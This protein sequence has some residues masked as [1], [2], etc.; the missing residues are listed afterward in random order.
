MACSRLYHTSITALNIW[1]A[2]GVTFLGL[3][4]IATGVAFVIS[5]FQKNDAQYRIWVIITTV[6]WCL[7]DVLSGSYSVLLTH[8]PLLGVAVVSAWIHDRP[9]K[10]KND[11]VSAT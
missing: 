4:V 10:K 3:L 1:V 2:H 8:V 5:I 7:Y 6:I 9:S 11:T